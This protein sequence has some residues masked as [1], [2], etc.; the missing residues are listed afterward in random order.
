MCIGVPHRVI[1]VEGEMALVEAYG[2]QKRVSLLLL[3]EPPQ[4]GDYLLVQ[5]GDFAAEIIEPEHARRA[6]AYYQSIIVE[7]EQLANN[8]S[9]HSGGVRAPWNL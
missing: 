1:E 7:A 2:K 6:M 8:E 3:A 4:A 9:S 5:V